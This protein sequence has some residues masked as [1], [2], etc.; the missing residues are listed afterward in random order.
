[1]YVC[2]CVFVCMCV[3]MYVGVSMYVYANV[4]WHMRMYVCMQIC[5]VSLCVIIY[6]E[7]ERCTLYV[8]VRGFLGMDASIHVLWCMCKDVRRTLYVGVRG[9][10]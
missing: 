5:V 7:D 6:Y 2:M 10:L 4:C 9:C 1:M 3:R 8:S